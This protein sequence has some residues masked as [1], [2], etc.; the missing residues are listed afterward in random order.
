MNEDRMQEFVAGVR[1]IIAR[2]GW[3]VI[4]TPV[5]ETPRVMM[6]YSVGISETLD[7]PEI[8]VFG[9]PTEVGRNLINT[10][11][12]RWRDGEAVR[13]GV[14]IERLLEGFD[15]YVLPVPKGVTERRLFVAN[16]L[17]DESY[18]CVQ[19]VWPDSAGRFPWQADFD[20]ALRDAQ[21]LIAKTDE[22]ILTGEH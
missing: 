13:V 2:V 9:L 21:P 20:P 10:L 8:V 6:S 22:L 7:R 11:A 3:A 18:E 12:G 4:G 17:M 15:A 16:H 5:P 19:L 14:P 1:E